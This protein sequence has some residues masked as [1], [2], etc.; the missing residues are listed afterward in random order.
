MKVQSIDKTV[1]NFVP[2]IGRLGKL[3]SHPELKRQGSIRLMGGTLSIPRRPF[4]AP[5]RTMANGIPIFVGVDS[6]EPNSITVE[7]CSDSSLYDAMDVIDKGIGEGGT[8]DGLYPSLYHSFSR[9]KKSRRWSL[10]CQIPQL[11]NA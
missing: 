6:L 3:H 2:V 10:I 8:N 5:R 4:V 7:L 9:V 11:N 1:N